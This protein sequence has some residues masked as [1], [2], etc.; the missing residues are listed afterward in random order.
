MLSPLPKGKTPPQQGFLTLSL[1]WDPTVADA[2]ARDAVLN[3][4]NSV[5]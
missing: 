3:L 2:C 1:A 5:L 4:P